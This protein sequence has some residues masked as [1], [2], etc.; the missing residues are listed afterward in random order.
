LSTENWTFNKQ[1]ETRKYKATVPGTIH[2][3]L[4]QQHLIPDPFYG[5]NEKKLQWI[6]NESWEYETIFSVSN[7]ELS[8]ENIE[9]EFNGLDTYATVFLNG[10]SILEADNMFRKWV[11]LAKNNLV[12]LL[13][14]HKSLAYFLTLSI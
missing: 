3:D 2:A 13:F 10:N 4:F 7:S 9:L 5:A 1:N 11:I 6:E 14:N 8:A 12:T